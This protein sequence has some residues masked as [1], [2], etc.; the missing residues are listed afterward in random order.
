[1]ILRIKLILFAMAPMPCVTPSES[2][3][4]LLL[5]SPALLSSYTGLLCGSQTN[6]NCSQ[7]RVSAL[8][9]APLEHTFPLFLHE[10]LLFEYQ[11]CF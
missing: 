9:L 11:Y 10:K 5:S 2:V 6:K 1:M 8:A 4:N 3:S 7:C